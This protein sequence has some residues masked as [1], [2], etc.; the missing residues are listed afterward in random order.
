MPRTLLTSE[1]EK[2]LDD[3][4]ATVDTIS[5]AQQDVLKR[6]SS[7]E[8]RLEAIKKLPAGSYPRV[9]GATALG[10]GIGAGSR[11]HLGTTVPQTTDGSAESAKSLH[12]APIELDPSSLLGTVGS[13]T[14]P[15]GQFVSGGSLYSSVQDEFNAIK[16]KVS[17]VKLP[18]ELRVGNSRSGIKR[19]DTNSAN[20]ITNSA[21]YAE[22]T[23]KLLW[24]I[25]VEEPD[26]KLLELFNVQ[27]AHIDYLRQEH[28]AL[29]VSGQFGS[30]T[31][32]LFKNLTRGT[33]N[34]DDKSLDSLLKAVQITSNDNTPHRGGYRGGRAGYQNRGRSFSGFRCGHHAQGG[35]VGRGQQWGQ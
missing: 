11:T 28:S 20:I 21:K 31:S 34:L 30:K 33:T 8:T 19:E 17:S 16:D 29:V 25:E 3:L 18:P 10:V 9:G 1:M 5:T 12:S 6:M 22:T 35:G 4:I 2:K 15:H 26:E 32:T 13:G 27:K 24:S 14:S 23:L 7:V